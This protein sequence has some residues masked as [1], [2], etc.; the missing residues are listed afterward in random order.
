[1]TEDQT[2]A[3][4]EQLRRR[5]RRRRRAR[6]SVIDC[7][8][9]RATGVEIGVFQGDFSAQILAIAE[10]KKLILLDPWLNRADPGLAGSKYASGSFYDMGAI[11]AAVQARFA[12]EISTGRVELLRA[13]A[14][15]L[16]RHV[17]DATLDFVY[18]D[19]D[20]RYEA[21]RHDIDLAIRKLRSGGILALDDYHER[22]W[23]G[24]DVVAAIH[25]AIGR[26]GAGLRVIHAAGD[27]IALRKT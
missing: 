10:P 12:D 6:A 15:A 20:H 1:M 4:D 11:Y 2:T 16:D 23:W 22:G 24:D 25:D 8:P 3:D 26:H 7:F 9:K 14:A 18:I 19:G 5:R 21:V 27:N 17:A 13:E